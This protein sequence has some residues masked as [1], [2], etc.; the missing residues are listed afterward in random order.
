MMDTNRRT[1]VSHVF[2]LLFMKIILI[3]L[4]QKRIPTK[5]GAQLRLVQIEFANMECG[6]IVRQI[7]EVKSNM[8]IKLII[9]NFVHF[10]CVLIYWYILMP[11]QSLIMTSIF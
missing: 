3:T 5:I 1:L 9:T 4:A 10:L 2:S 7:A 6:D 11:G 8:T